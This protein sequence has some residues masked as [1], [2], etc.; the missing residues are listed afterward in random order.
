MVGVGDA[1]PVGDVAETVVYYGSTTPAVEAAAEAVARSMTGSVIM[2]YDP[3]QVTDGAEVTVVTGTQFAVDAPVAAATP[4]TGAVGHARRL[5][6]VDGP[7]GHH[8]PDHVPGC[9]CHCRSV[10]HLIQ[11]RAVGSPCLRR[12]APA[13]RHRWPIRPERTPPD[14]VS[15]RSPIGNRC[16]CRG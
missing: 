12:R 3:S 13:R 1:P 9:G 6:H 5:H 14:P 16:S 15:R 10:A 7:A 2:A 8:H 4:A 11:P